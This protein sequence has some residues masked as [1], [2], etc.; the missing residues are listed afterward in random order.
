MKA[1]GPF[2]TPKRPIGDR[3]QF[4]RLIRAM[5]SPKAAVIAVRSP[6]YLYGL[7]GSD[8]NL[9]AGLHKAGGIHS[10]GF[11]DKMIDHRCIRNFERCHGTDLI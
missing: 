3:P 9:C 2:S 7:R 11:D 6:S 1:D 8:V 5:N 4:G 10:F